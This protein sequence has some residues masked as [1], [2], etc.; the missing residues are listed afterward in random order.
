MGFFN[1]NFN[2]RRNIVD[3]QPEL[4]LFVLLQAKKMCLV[5]EHFFLDSLSL[6]WF[7]LQAFVT[8]LDMPVI[9]RTESMR[10]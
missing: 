8:K 5:S 4:F 10:Y 3:E 9:I 6:T 2:I 7:R 1:Y